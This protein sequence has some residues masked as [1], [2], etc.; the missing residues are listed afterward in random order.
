M[1]RGK[2]EQEMHWSII[3]KIGNIGYVGGGGGGL[4]EGEYTTWG[5]GVLDPRPFIHSTG[6]I[7]SPAIK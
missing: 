1:G 6:C 5:G 7:A 4:G 3:L 2:N